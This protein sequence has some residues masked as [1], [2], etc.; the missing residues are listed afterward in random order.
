MPS[1]TLPLVAG[2]ARLPVLVS[3]SAPTAA[4]LHRAQQPVPSPIAALA[5]IDSGASITGVDLPLLGQLG[6]QSGT[7][8]SLHTPV[9]GAVPQSFPLY[10]VSLTLPH[11]AVVSYHLGLLPV[12][13]ANLAAQGIQVL[14]GRDV[15]AHC[16]FI[17]NGP[18]DTY[19][20][21]F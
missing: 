17:Y 2:E 13:G 1:I 20:L 12:V 10:E 9:T 19:T 18:G 4:D 7:T 15:L 6:L 3:V 11:P 8:R 16:V 21:C 14:L 5:E